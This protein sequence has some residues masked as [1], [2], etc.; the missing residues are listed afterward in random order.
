MHHIVKC[1]QINCPNA[2]RSQK[3]RHTSSRTS[4]SRYWHVSSASTG[5]TT[6]YST[7]SLLLQSVILSGGKCSKTPDSWGERSESDT[8]DRSKFPIWTRYS[9][10]GKRTSSNRHRT[11]NSIHPRIINCIKNKQNDSD[12]C[13]IS[14]TQGASR[15]SATSMFDVFLPGDSGSSSPSGG[16]CSK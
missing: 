3:H 2:C 14:Q 9:P 8:S 6:S 7:A 11:E 12:I 13:S 10:S 15:G 5:E 16:Y 4:Q 1:P